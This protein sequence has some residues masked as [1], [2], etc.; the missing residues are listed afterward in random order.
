MLFCALYIIIIVIII[1]IIIII[2]IVIIMILLSYEE[3]IR[4]HWSPVIPKWMQ[5]IPV[6]FLL[7]PGWLPFCSLL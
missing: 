5:R 2:I 6:K 1:I 4:L 3:P 7:L